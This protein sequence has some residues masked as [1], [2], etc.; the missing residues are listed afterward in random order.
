VV[1]CGA[2]SCNKLQCLL[3]LVVLLLS[4]GPAYTHAKCCSSVLQCNAVWCIILTK[5]YSDQ[6]TCITYR[7]ANLHR[8]P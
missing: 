3:R 5:G 6:T 1:Q 2:V 8:I 4:A 7:V